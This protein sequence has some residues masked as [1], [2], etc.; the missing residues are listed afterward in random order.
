MDVIV[1][2]GLV[3]IV[4]V[5]IQHHNRTIDFPKKKSAPEM[6]ESIVLSGSA[7]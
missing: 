1:L 4:G 2:V 5:K 7:T 6:L 3:R